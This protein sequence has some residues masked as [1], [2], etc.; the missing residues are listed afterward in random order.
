MTT[1][2]GRKKEQAELLRLSNSNQAELV[3]VYG[4]RRV[5]KTYLIREMFAD[6]FCF[7]HTGVST[8]ELNG[9]RLTE[10][11]LTAFVTSLQYYGANISKSPKNWF[12]AF[13]ILKM[14]L[15]PKLRQ[16]RQIVFIDELPWLDTPKS[17]FLSAFENFWNGWGAGQHNL[18]LIVCGSSTSWI[19]NNLINNYG[20][21][22]DR[23]TWEIQLSPFNLKESDEFLKSKNVILSQYDT[24][25]AYMAVGGIPFYLNYFMP[26]LSTAQNIDELFFVHKA[27][28]KD[29]FNRLFKSL[30]INPE[31]YVNIIKY[32]KKRN[33]GY[34]RDEICKGTGISSG[35]GL[36]EILKTLEASDFIKSYIPFGCSKRQVTYK[37]SDNFCRFYLTFVEG[38]D[39]KDQ[40]YWSNSQNHG[41]ITAWKGIAFEEVCFAH[42]QQIK[43]ALRIGGVTSSESAWNIDGSDDH[44]GA[45]IDMIIERNDGV[46]NM[47]EMKF[48]KSEFEVSEKYSQKIAERIEILSKKL[49][50]NQYIHSTLVTT[51][52]LKPGIHSNAFQ[53]V[54]TMDELFRD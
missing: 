5:G 25:Q 1:I 2:I 8:M 35:R 44:E 38:N 11:Q 37:L 52:G 19:K 28:L 45:Q 49:S 34:T 32:L 18:M 41:S 36:S 9:K 16:S 14:F 23:V 13:N 3:A 43:D 51:S 21:L 7:Y 30:F 24:I 20:G 27:K 15:E 46:V 33:K 40:N 10:R 31:N 47:C 12:E 17:E 6:R 29:E 48:L 39:T 54:V 42:I 22:Y 4:R 26:G 53:K 50:Q